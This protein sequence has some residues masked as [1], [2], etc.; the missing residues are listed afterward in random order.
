VAFLDTVV[1]RMQFTVNGIRVDGDSEF[2]AAFEVGCQRRGLYLFVLQSRSPKLNG[3]V[4]RPAHAYR[5]I[6]LTAPLYELYS[7]GS[8]P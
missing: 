7:R 4:E 6:L 1:A 5:G 8:Q 2:H 3:A